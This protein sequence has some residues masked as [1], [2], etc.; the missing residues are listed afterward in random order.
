MIVPIDYAGKDHTVQFCLGNGDLLLNRPLHVYNNKAG[1]E[2]LKTRIDKTCRKEHIKK[3]N[4][5]GNFS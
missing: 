3:Q 4:E 1:S 5:T 2:F